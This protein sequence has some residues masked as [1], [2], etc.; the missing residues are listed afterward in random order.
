[1]LVI[2]AQD[3]PAWVPVVSWVG[4]AALLFTVWR[5]WRAGRREDERE[6]E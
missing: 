6:G 2:A 3:V 5:G 1:V 4:L